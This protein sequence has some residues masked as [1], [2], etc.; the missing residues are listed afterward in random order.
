MLRGVATASHEF[1]VHPWWLW[2]L[3]S[4]IIESPPPLRPIPKALQQVHL[5]QRFDS[6]SLVVI[7]SC[8]LVAQQ[9]ATA[10]RGEDQTPHFAQLGLIDSA[11]L[12]VDTAWRH[13]EW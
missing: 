12:S 13:Y 6:K 7:V 5:S 1:Q 3:R 4:A 9:T 2:A 10:S 8:V 11:M